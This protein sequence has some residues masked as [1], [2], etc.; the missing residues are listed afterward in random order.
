MDTGVSHG[1]NSDI[2]GAFQRACAVGLVDTV[3]G[4]GN[5]THHQ[6]LRFIVLSAAGIGQS[7]A[8]R[9][10]FDRPGADRLGTLFDPAA[11]LRDSLT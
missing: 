1:G 5:P 4:A 8:R 6:D 3:T 10:S 11:I 9:R 7:G 2:R